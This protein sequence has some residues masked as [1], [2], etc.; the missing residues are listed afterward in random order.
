MTD[1]DPL[2]ER[3]QGEAEVRRRQLLEE[4]NEDAQRARLATLLQVEDVR[5]FLWLVMGWCGIFEDPMHSNFGHVAY[6]LGKAA[7]GKKLLIRINEADPS[8]WRLMQ[9]KAA[10]AEL[11]RIRAETKKRDQRARRAR[12]SEAIP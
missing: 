12:S 11:E 6:G 5:D 7:I 8:A 2:E 10:Q 9:E 1:L 4:L 3:D